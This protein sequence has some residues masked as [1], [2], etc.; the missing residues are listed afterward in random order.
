MNVLAVTLLFL[1]ALIVPI[2]RPRS[3]S[4]SPRETQSGVVV[5][6]V[7]LAIAATLA[8]SMEAAGRVDRH[9]HTIGSMH[10]QAGGLSWMMFGA[11][12]IFCARYAFVPELYEGRGRALDRLLL[13]GPP[14]ILSVLL[15]VFEVP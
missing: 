14:L 11:F 10:A 5:A 8:G 12:C 4:T 13:F 9:G 6:M 7:V 3:S 1:A 15:A 2:F